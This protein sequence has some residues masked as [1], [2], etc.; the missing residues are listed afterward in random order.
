MP[1]KLVFEQT[2]PCNAVL[3]RSDDGKLAYRSSTPSIT[4]GKRVT[5]ITRIDRT[6]LEHLVASLKWEEPVKD[7]S[8]IALYNEDWRK[9]TT[10]MSQRRQFSPYVFY[11][12]FTVINVSHGP[13]VRYMKCANGGEY[14]WI[15]YFQVRYILYHSKQSQ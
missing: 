12:V 13:S 10:F 1:L 14:K 8:E 6:G 4:L 5:K 9:I 7:D 11:S 3:V 2:D 15:R